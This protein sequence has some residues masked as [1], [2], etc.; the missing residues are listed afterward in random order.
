MKVNTQIYGFNNLVLLIPHYN[1][2]KGLEDSLNSIR[3]VELVNVL[4]VDD[5]SE[6]INKPKQSYLITKYKGKLNLQ[7]NELKVNQGIEHALNK[8]LNTSKSNGYYYVARLDCG[9]ISLPNRLKVQLDFFNKN[10]NVKILGT[11][12]SH[13]D[14]D[15]NFLYNSKLPTDYN[16]IKKKFFINCLLYH[17]TVM[18]QLDTALSFG[19]YPTNYPAAEDYGL[20]MKIV[21]KHKA[22]NLNEIFVEKLID[23]KS[24]SNL[25]RKEQIRSRIRI[26]L[27]NMHFGFYPVYGLIRCFVLYLFP[28]KTIVF[29]RSLI[30][31]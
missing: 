8:G 5:G 13:H 22:I 1:N 19:G 25:R 7:F 9:D 10:Q 29:V 2:P 30:S 14:K 17:P 23:D 4:I 27:D 18:F 15:G 12:V 20:F 28:R 31:K 24:I 6:A 16:E 11:Q 26:I 3:E 21:K